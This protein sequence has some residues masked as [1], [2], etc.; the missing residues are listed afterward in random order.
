MIMAR[1][2]CMHSAGSGCASVNTLSLAIAID[3]SLVDLAGDMCSYSSKLQLIMDYIKEVDSQ[4]VP[5]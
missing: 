4:Q 3:V 2:I 1:C 5:V